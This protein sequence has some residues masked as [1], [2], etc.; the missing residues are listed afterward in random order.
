MIQTPEARKHSE[1]LRDALNGFSDW[2]NRP[3]NRVHCFTWPLALTLEPSARAYACG[4]R[5]KPAYRRHFPGVQEWRNATAAKLKQMRKA[6]KI[7]LPTYDERTAKWIQASPLRFMTREEACAAGFNFRTK[8]N[9]PRSL[10]TI[11]QQLIGEGYSESV[12][13][14]QVFHTAT[15]SGTVYL[16][17]VKHPAINP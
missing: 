2:Q 5:Y 11:T 10:H 14:K 3:L 17:F 6:G 16:F 4:I 9:N 13:V 1:E 15:P 7:T 8:T 12:I